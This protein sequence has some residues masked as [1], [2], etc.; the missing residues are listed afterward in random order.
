M[1]R[2]ILKIKAINLR[3]SLADGEFFKA[4]YVDNIFSQS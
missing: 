2:I 4:R 3:I 1:E